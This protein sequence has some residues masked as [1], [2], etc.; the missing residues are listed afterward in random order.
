M[1]FISLARKAA[2][3]ARHP[4]L[5]AWLYRSTRLAAADL[6]RRESRRRAHE[7]AAGSDPTVP[8]PDSSDLDW[9]KLAPV[10][11]DAVAGLGERD[12]EAI[13]LRFFANQPF[14]EVGRRLQVTDNAARMRVDRALDKLRRIL[15]DRGIKSS[16]VALASLLASEAVA[17]VPPAIPAAIASAALSAGVGSAAAGILLFMNT[18]KFAAGVLGTALVASVG[19]V[20]IQKTENRQLSDAVEQARVAATGLSEAQRSSNALRAQ[21]DEQ[22]NLEAQAGA[23]IPL[24]TKAKSLEKEVSDLRT[25]VTASHQHAV[26]SE[27]D[28]Y[29]I[30]ALDQA[31]RATFQ[32]RPQYPQ[33]VRAS[34]GTGQVLVD[35]VVDEKGNVANASVASSTNPGLEQAAVDAVSQWTFSPGQKTG[36]AVA[37]HMQVP[38]VFTLSPED[39]A[40]STAVEADSASSQPGYSLDATHLTKFTVSTPA[41]SPHPAPPSPSSWFPGEKG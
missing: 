38:I 36:A 25:Q 27:N 22:R 32:V 39:A 24:Y 12:R 18:T 33:S 17:V 16:A 2:A 10:L 30:S 34:G 19:A 4:A 9:R 3:L 40:D 5:A 29:D 20:A 13:I 28:V 1:V 8:K 21:V 7:S 6:F 31:P 15:E 26:R 23:A 11:D 14:A 41:S 37:T 35:F